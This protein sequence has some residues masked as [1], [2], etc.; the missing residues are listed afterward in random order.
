[1]NPLAP[2]SLSGQRTRAAENDSAGQDEH[3]AAP[4][5]ARFVSLRLRLLG[6]VVLMLVPWLMLVIYTQADER[7][8]AVANV[9]ADAMRF[10]RIVTSNQ[11]AQLEAARQLLTAFARLPQLHTGDAVACNAF[12]T[13]MLKAYP[14]YL[15]FTVAEPNG[16]VL[17]SAVPLRSRATAA[18]RPYF[19]A[20]METG[21][22]AIGDYQVGRITQLPAINYASPLVAPSGNIE[23][24]VIAAQSLNWLTAAL[25]N[26]EFPPDA[27][28]M[29]T[30]RNG[31]VLARLPDPGDWI[32]KTLPEKEVLATL[33]SQSEGGVFQAHDAHGI[34]RLWAHAPLLPGSNLH[35]TIGASK[36]VALADINR[37]LIRNLVGLALVT[38]VALAA[39]WSGGKFILRQVDALVAATARLASGDLGA[40]A[41]VLGGR[42]ELEM[43][44]RAFNTMAATLQ[45]RERELRIAEERTRKAEVELAV[46][47][48][49]MDIAKQIQ[50]SLLPEDPLTMACVRYAGRCIP[51]A[52]VGGDY[53][54]YFPRGG[55]GVDSLVGDVS[56]HGVGAALLMAQARTVFLAERL[57]APSAAQIL[58]K[59]N[60]LLHHD[61]DRAGFFITACCAI[62]D[63]ATREL[64]YANAGHP[65]ALLLRASAKKCTAIDAEGILLGVTK[66]AEFTEVKVELQ[67]GDIVVF[68]TDGITE[69]R[70]ASGDMFGVQRLG[71]T[72]ATHRADDPETL[73]DSVLATLNGFAGGTQHEDDLTIVVM[74][75]TG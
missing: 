47:R 27:I 71:E 67:T 74:K 52:A 25:S 75:L 28:L 23:G 46:T 1:M 42:S 4:A 32:G 44:A 30:D 34:D 49:H 66:E 53:F 6:L 17:C 40:R 73:V 64:S 55:E 10:I 22:F 68:Y 13:E 35:A 8:V 50:R 12:L 2:R 33:S 61:L 15:N 45:A 62:F 16:D 37:R 58:T 41:A 43:L 29:V 57:V 72:V 18:D 38:L 63:A 3:D 69:A 51:A 19:K 5:H 59:L 65:P 21:R 31:T 70:N 24:V 9:N 11:A 39:A 54:G 14:L 48:A 7:R 20:A 26:V 36:A 56:G 60:E